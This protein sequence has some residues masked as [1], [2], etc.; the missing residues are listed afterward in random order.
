MKK[1]LFA[2]VA[3]GVAASAGTAAAQSPIPFSVGGRA[4]YVI[5]TGD[6]KDVAENGVSFGASASVGVARGLGVYGSYDYA[7]FGSTTNE[8][9]D[10]VDKGFSAGIT[11][12]IPTGSARV[13]PYIGGGA[14]FHQLEV[15]GSD[16]GIDSKT[17]FELGGG[18]AF[19]VAPGLVLS[20]SVGYRR[21]EA[22]LPVALG[23]AESSL[24][25][26]YFSAGVGLSIAF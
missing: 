25:V 7:T 4:D 16:Q 11:A 17:G 3:L 26:E 9:A 19:D 12:A 20:P 15:D 22:K 8:D 14:V 13:R 6:F 23:L 2:A 21:Y 10:A 1:V 5:P 18:L 24:N